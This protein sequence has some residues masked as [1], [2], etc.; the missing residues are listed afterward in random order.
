MLIAIDSATAWCGIA[1]YDQANQ[2]V[3]EERTWRTRADHCRQ[4]L[5]EIDA[6]LRAQGLS[7]RDLTGV[8]VVLGPG[9]FNGVRV[10]VSTAKLLARARGIPIVGVNTFELYAWADRGT[11][12]LVR[13][14]LGAARGEVGT[15]LWRATDPPRE[16]EPM[17]LA[18]PADLLVPP[19]EPTLFTGELEPD[20]RAKIATLGPTAV[21]AT[22]AQA[23]RRPAVLAELTARR[24]AAGM[25]QD[26]AALAPI[27]LRPPHITAPRR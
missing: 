17:C 14:V 3:L 12:R 4:L 26:V 2:V 13:A 1:L 9:T 27:Y 18:S 19:A 6:A 15:A 21:A 11:N 16:I 7:A 22:G 5:P 8:A 24:I 20:W 25:V 23:L 10:A